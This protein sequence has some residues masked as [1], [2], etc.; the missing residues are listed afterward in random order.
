MTDH[1]LTIHTGDTIVAMPTI[2]TG[3]LVFFHTVDEAGKYMIPSEPFKEAYFLEDALKF[4]KALHLP[5]IYVGGAPHWSWSV[6][7]TSRHSSISSP[8]LNPSRILVFTVTA[9]SELSTDW[10]PHGR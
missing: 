2:A 1:I 5:L 10:N 6:R 3:V 8:P 7:A 4:R 9:M